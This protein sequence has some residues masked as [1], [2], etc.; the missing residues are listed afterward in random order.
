MQSMRWCSVHRTGPVFFLWAKGEGILFWNWCSEICVL[1]SF[2]VFS[3]RYFY[4]P[5]L[6]SPSSCLFFWCC[7]HFFTQIF[8]GSQVVSKASNSMIQVTSCH[9]DIQYSSLLLVIG[10]FDGP[11]A[12]KCDQ[13]LIPS[14]VIISKTFEKLWCMASMNPRILWSHTNKSGIHQ[15]LYKLEAWKFRV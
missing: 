5:K 2:I 12:K 11:I 7:S 9:W 4:V 13:T 15:S 6:F 1:Y 3:Q 14:K 8:M 10:L